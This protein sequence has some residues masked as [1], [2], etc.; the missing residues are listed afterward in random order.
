MNKPNFY[1]TKKTTKASAEKKHIATEF[2]MDCLTNVKY[3]K[4]Y[5]NCPKYVIPKP[6]LVNRNFIAD[7]KSIYND[8]K[9]S[10]NS[11]FN[12]SH[13]QGFPPRWIYSATLWLKIQPCSKN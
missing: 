5:P 1:Y 2:E 4:C 11:L 12:L 6:Y 9:V 3:R 7:N 13:T 8:Y 10:C